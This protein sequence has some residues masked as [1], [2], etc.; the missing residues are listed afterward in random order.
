MNL[1]DLAHPIRERT[2]HLQLKV[3]LG[4][5]NPDAIV[6]GEQM[7]QVNAF[8]QMNDEG[9]DQ[10]PAGFSDFLDS[11]KICRIALHQTGIRLVLTDQAADR[12]AKRLRSL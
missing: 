11:A 3:L 5:A 12:S 2:N 10:V 8:G 7:K 1:F 9:L 4:A 6:L